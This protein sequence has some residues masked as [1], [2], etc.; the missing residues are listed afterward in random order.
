MLTQWWFRSLL[1][2]TLGLTA[3]SFMLQSPF[4]TLDDGFS[5]VTN[6]FIRD[7]RHIGELFTQGYFGDRSYYRPLVNLSFMGEYRA[8][9]LRAFF[10]NFDNLLLHILN[11]FLVWALV[12]L[13]S[14]N[15]STGFWAGLL[16]VI[17]PIHVEAVA[18][19][20][21][22]A[23][24]LSTAFVLTSFIS[25]LFYE[26]GGQWRFL[27]GSL[28]SFALGLL[29]KES[30]AVLPAV[31]FFY[32]WLN[33]KAVARL[34]PFIGII[35]FYLVL[36]VY[37][38]LTQTFS[39]NNVTQGILGFVTFLRSILTD[40]RLFVF[41]VDLHFDRSQPMF[42]SFTNFEFLTTIFMWTVFIV[43]LWQSRRHISTSVWFCL[44]WFSCGL[45]PVSQIVTSIGVAP[46]VISTADHFL[47]LASVP[48]FILSI[49][50]LKTLWQANWR[51]QWI[52]SSIFKTITGAFLVFLFLMNI[53]QNIYDS[54][55]LSM[56]ERSLQ[57]Q[58]FNPRLESSVGL[59]YAL[60]DKFVQAQ[61]HFTK[62]VLE[63]PSNPRY[64]ISLGKSLCDQGR[65]TECLNV[66]N[67]IKD[68]GGFDKLLDNN[69]RAALRLLNQHAQIR[70][71]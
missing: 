21:G 20:S 26:R 71:K 11:A 29:C 36:R 34:W 12:G 69:K 6:P 19:I 63:D 61:V 2:V 48:I 33:K 10:F 56:L 25:F 64:R 24:L 51:K 23:I 55:E 62:A 49:E 37:L 13:I 5:I 52:H 54:N 53:E 46:G 35:F 9:G 50:G 65:Y 7:S 16:F 8:F 15:P 31:I 59:I 57:I 40:L 66:Y 39:W 70:S 42:L 4:K 3:Y 47:Y 30:S 68:A 38:G 45:L 27:S 28:F 18:N 1:I 58:P 14:A 67:Q 44:L 32:L 22:R 43:C 41:P 17:H 60:S